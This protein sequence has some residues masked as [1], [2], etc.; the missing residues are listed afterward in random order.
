M[1]GGLCLLLEEVHSV[2]LSDRNL[3]FFDKNKRAVFIKKTVKSQ[4]I[5]QVSWAKQNASGDQEA[6][7]ADTNAAAPVVEPPNTFSPFNFF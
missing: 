4:D 2:P 1:Q 6:V 5:M 3:N 7:L